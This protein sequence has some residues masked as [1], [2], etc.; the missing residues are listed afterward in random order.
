[1]A[2]LSV[3]VPVPTSGDGTPVSIANFVGEKTV[4]LTGFFKG[5]YVILAGHELGSLVPV[6]Q[7]D[8]GGEAGIEQTL[9]EAYQYVAVRAQVNNVVLGAP[10]TVTVNAVS[11]VGQNG[12]APLATLNPG[13]LGPQPS[14]DTYTLFPPTGLEE[15]ISVICRGLFEGNVIIE[16]SDDNVEWNP[17]G[18]FSATPVGRTLLGLPRILEFGPLSTKDLVRYLRVNSAAKITGVTT[19][20][21]GGRIPASGVVPPASVSSLVGE[22]S[23]GRST[24]LNAAGEEILY[25]EPVDLS[26]VPAGHLLSPSFG[27]V[28]KVSSASSGQFKLYFGSVTPGSTAGATALAVLNTTSLTSELVT[29]AG[30]FLPNPGGTV[31]IQVTGINDTPATCV[32]KISSMTWRLS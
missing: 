4:V 19:L 23:T 27:G 11:G 12:F 24:T 7:F 21:V 14:I 32:S 15:E 6:L 29:G 17:I 25:E 31:L 16:G 18:Q 20:T 13:D 5:L 2:I 8:A 9:S 3:S 28:I 30:S 22:D 10:V 26:A 1:M